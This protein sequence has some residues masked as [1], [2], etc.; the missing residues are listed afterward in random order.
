MTAKEK[1]AAAPGADEDPTLAADAPAESDAPDAPE[2]DAAPERKGKKAADASPLDAPQPKA[3]K[4]VPASTS[5]VAASAAAFSIAGDN[6]VRIID[7]DGNTV[8]PADMFD[9]PDPHV[10][11]VTARTRLYEEFTQTNSTRLTTRLLYP[12]GAR[13]PRDRADKV[14]AAVAEGPEFPDE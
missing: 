7:E 9:D 2:A 4:P 10:S 8:D 3:D 11:F 14:R 1:A 13:V 12:A 5:R 6:H